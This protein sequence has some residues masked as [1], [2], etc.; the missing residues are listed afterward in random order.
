MATSRQ[1]PKPRQQKRK[2][3]V[4]TKTN[5]D[6]SSINKDTSQYD[7]IAKRP[8]RRH[9]EDVAKVNNSRQNSIDVENR[10]GGGTS[11]HTDMTRR[12][13][14]KKN[15]PASS[16]TSNVK[17]NASSILQRMRCSTH[18]TG[19]QK[20][21][22]NNIHSAAADEE[23]SSVDESSDTTRSDI[24]DCNE[25]M[26]TSH[27]TTNTKDKEDTSAISGDDKQTS[28]YYIAYIRERRKL[29]F[30]ILTLVIFGIMLLTILSATIHLQHSNHN[31]IILESAIT[32]QSSQEQLEQTYKRHNTQMKALT[33]INN[34]LK[35]DYDE[36]NTH[37][38]HVS[39]QYNLLQHNHIELA[40]IYLAPILTYVNMLQQSYEEQHSI[41]LDLMKSVQSL[42]SSL[43]SCNEDIETQKQE[44]INAVE[45]V[46][47]ASNQF[48]LVKAQAHELERINYIEH[49]ELTIDRIEDEAIGAVNAVATAAG[50]LEYERKLEEEERWKRYTKEAESILG[51]I[52]NN[53][54]QDDEVQHNSDKVGDTDVYKTSV[55]KAAI[56]RRIEEGLTS[57]RSYVYPYSY[58]KRREDSAS[59][60]IE[61]N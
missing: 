38:Q 59:T 15:I 4:D 52:R 24:S 37:T 17:R 21:V 26:N 11:L 23:A 46:A 45:A 6:S 14:S 28:N 51:S 48:A 58:L 49:M 5:D 7:F 16:S 50:K 31:L 56:S 44:S 39:M 8:C 60:N 1:P 33:E 10:R 35:R 55:L 18:D 40:D 43:T 19:L 41:I 22:N 57:L 13:V 34:V 29:Q 27:N 61:V 30:M 32:S 12:K 2:R 3:K 9:R 36:I 25:T 42:Q 54:V 20:D 53:V 47:H